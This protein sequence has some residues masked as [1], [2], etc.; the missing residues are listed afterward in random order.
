MTDDYD[1]KNIRFRAVT[2]KDPF[3]LPAC[4]GL[5]FCCSGPSGAP[6][7]GAAAWVDGCS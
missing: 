3:T 5:P 6:A 1:T 7:Q 2:D 4:H